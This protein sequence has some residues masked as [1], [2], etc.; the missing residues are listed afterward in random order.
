MS[1]A[2]VRGLYAL[3]PDETDTARL[4][5]LVEA[6]VEGGA[7]LVQYRNKIAPPEL[8]LRQ[9]EALRAICRR[10]AVPLIVNDDPAV[11]S[12]VDADGVH[13]GRDD[14]DI[15]E[16]RARLPGRLLGVSCY[17]EIARAIAAERAGADYVAF[18]RFFASVTK[19]GDIRA[20]LELLAEAR[21]RIRVPIVAIGGITLE[22]TPALIASGAD[23]VAV[24]S[25]LFS[26][27]DVR[28]TARRF[29]ALFTARA[30]G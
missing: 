19:P 25:A 24:I 14:G 18:G 13:L 11:A 30:D 20:S 1:D 16:A 9:A 29:A 17:N 23:A 15:A 26:S 8:R 12:A 3:T 2:R 6:A 27:S 21:R 7:R 28:A 5:A 22:Q 4:A 10:S